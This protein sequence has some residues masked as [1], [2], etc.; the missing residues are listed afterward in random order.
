MDPE[1]NVRVPQ[2][3]NV[4]GGKKGVFSFQQGAAQ[5]VALASHVTPT[6]RNAAWQGRSVA[7]TLP[8]RISLLDSTMRLPQPVA[9]PLPMS[10]Q[11]SKASATALR[12][13]TPCVRSLT[14][15]LLI[16]Y[17]TL[18][19]GAGL[20]VNGIATSHGNTGVLLSGLILSIGRLVGAWCIAALFKAVPSLNPTPPLAGPKHY[21]RGV[22]TVAWAALVGFGQSMMNVVFIYAN[23]MGSVAIYGPL[24]GLH[25]AVTMT[26]GLLAQS[27]PRTPSRIFGIVL[28]AASVVLLGVAQSQDESS[29]GSSGSS[30]LRGA[31]R[32]LFPVLMGSVMIAGWGGL[33]ILSVEVGRR[34]PRSSAAFGMGCG[35][36]LAALL[37]ALACA[38]GLEIG[39]QAQPLPLRLDAF[40]WLLL[41]VNILGVT[42][43]IGF[44]ILGAI[45]HINEFV[46]VTSL[47]GVVTAALGYGVFLQSPSALAVVSV[48]MAAVA[49]VAVSVAPNEV[50]APAPPSSRGE[51]PPKRK[52]SVY[53]PSPMHSP[54]TLL[55]GS[56][57]A[58][59]Q[60]Q[61]PP[62]LSLNHPQHT[63][64][65]GK[66]A[67]G[68]GGGEATPLTPTD[69]QELQAA[70]V[71]AQWICLCARRSSPLGSALVWFVE[72]DVKCGRGST[73]RAA[74]GGMRG[75]LLSST[76]DD[77]DSSDR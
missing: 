76:S 13:G 15:P 38:G 16:L 23:T 43:W 65:G 50:E 21:M 51:P 56:L 74:E 33:D 73:A 19:M 11:H 20:F 55:R 5:T 41:A 7:C 61:S 59:E 37:L 35:Q 70:A 46:P 28:S 25:S 54:T 14:K 22:P 36:V 4:A 17:V 77:A 67:L 64:G 24:A 52:I 34:L 9:F 58:G 40:A 3:L 45:A 69:I 47:Y 1:L 31:W 57:L 48:L 32:V 68:G 18:L 27:Q 6:D 66:N 72:H 62:P 30:S 63:G 29:D 44:V 8:R 71:D 42:A 10:L 39:G 26:Y 75:A 53:N 49:V 12:R 2:Q 60:H